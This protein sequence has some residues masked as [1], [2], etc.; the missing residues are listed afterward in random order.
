VQPCRVV[1]LTSDSENAL[2]LSNKYGGVRD[3]SC[4]LLFECPRRSIKS[5]GL[6]ETVRGSNGWYKKWYAVV[7]RLRSCGGAVL[8]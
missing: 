7:F 6:Y 5:A 1:A 3:T 2:R 4:Y 8:I